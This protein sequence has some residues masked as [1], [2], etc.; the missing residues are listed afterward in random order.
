VLSC[1]AMLLGATAFK[2]Q[3]QTPATALN[4]WT[5]V[6]GQHSL[7]TAGVYGTL[8]VPASGNLP[9]SRVTASTWID[10]NGN[11]WLFGGFGSGPNNAQNQFLTSSL[12]DLWEYTPSTGFWTWQGGPTTG[13]QSGIYGTQGVAAAA[14][15][16]GGR[17][18]AAQWTDPRGNFWLFGGQGYDS[19]GN[20]GYLNDLWEFD[21]TTM[22]WAWQGGSNTLTQFG[23]A[24]G[25][26]GSAGSYGTENTASPANLPPGRSESA[27]AA[28]GQGNLWLFGG[29]GFTADNT[30]GYFNDL[31]KYDTSSKM[32][33][34]TAGA[35]Q[36]GQ[37]GSYGTQGVSYPASAHFPGARQGSSLWSTGNGILWLFGGQENQ[38][39]VQNDLWKIDTVSGQVTWVNGSST[40]GAAGN[41]GTISVPASS[42]VPGA[43]SYFA[44]WIDTNGNLWLFGGLGVDSAYDFGNLN[45]IW[46]F[47]QQT[48][49]WT[50]QNGSYDTD[51]NGTFA[52][53][54]TQ[55]VPA[56]SNQ[57][58]GL[59]MLM[60]WTDSYGN[61]WIYS[62]NALGVYGGFVDN[63][64]F[65]D[66][67]I[68]QPLA[69]NQQAQTI[70]FAAP[71]N[72]SAATP[73]VTLSA[74][75][76]SALPVVFASNSP[77]VCTVSGNTATIVT[78]GTCSIT[79]IQ[80]GNGS[81]T[82]A[83]PVTQT[84]QVVQDF[85]LAVSGA[86]SAVLTSG[87]SATFDLSFAPLPSASTSQNSVTLTYAAT[88]A[89]PAS[90]QVTLTPAS[91]PAGSGSTSV[92]L[93]VSAANTA[94]QNHAPPL[95]TGSEPISLCLLLL[96]I[97]PRSRQKMSPFRATAVLLI[98]L[99]GATSLAITGCGSSSQ[100]KPPVTY[101]IV[102]SATSGPVSHTA[103]VSLTIN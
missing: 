8:G 21:V 97:L 58:A 22:E 67:W 32:W 61:F 94:R 62:G 69:L 74:T 54:G 66:L 82:A 86:S 48:G 78:Y 14:N 56:A 34:W 73:S 12:N 10:K 102:V 42:N 100:S 52:N 83:T 31:W 60:N 93:V 35:S 37:A 15:L 40:T 68:Y 63:G 44:N 64:V 39:Y 72:V 77:Q 18:G 59:W 26:Y 2:V 19:A 9:G 101:Q 96:P 98:L 53:Y 3:A 70:T 65:D 36:I 30:S 25:D 49:M 46:M 47:N 76:S 99:A 4:E 7:A 33:T 29:F 103:N 71:N 45:D 79:A 75:A 85:T 24:T 80:P 43:R 88:P 6:D 11:F 51:F 38:N 1:A 84:F 57:P 89:L 50:W 87:S 17:Q 91:I 95:P 81:F 13:N 28:D 23:S 27:F 5:W 90:Y 41:Y 16:A 55:G 20:F 92:S